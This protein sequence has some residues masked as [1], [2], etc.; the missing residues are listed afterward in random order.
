VPTNISYVVPARAL[1]E[2]LARFLEDPVAE[3]P[4]DAL[5]LDE[6]LARSQM[7]NAMEHGRGWKL[8]GGGPD[9]CVRAL[10]TADKI[11]RG[12]DGG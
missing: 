12:A 2:C 7:V 3:S 6:M 9:E 5:T 10:D 1:R 11:C 4:E 8:V